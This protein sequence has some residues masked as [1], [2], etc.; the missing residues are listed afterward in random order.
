[1]QSTNAYNTKRVDIA[2]VIVTIAIVVII[3]SQVVYERGLQAGKIPLIAGTVVVVISIINYFLR[4]HQNVKALI[5]ALLP[6]LIV[7]ALFYFD[8]FAVNKHYMIIITIAMVT[9][10]FKKELILIYGIV[11]NI[12]MVVVYQIAPQGLM[13]ADDTILAFFKVLTMLDGILILLY[14]LTKWGN[15]LVNTAS[16]KEEESSK[17]LKKLEHSMKTMEESADTLDSNIGDIDTQMKGISDASKGILDSVQQMALAIQAE[18][19]FKVNETMTS[20]LD[21]VNQ[22]LQTSEGIVKKSDAISHKVEDGWNKM[23][24]VTEHMGTVNTA[25]GTTTDTVTELKIS[26]EEINHLLEG[27][28]T[29]AGQTNLLALNASI[30][31]ARAG[32]HGKGFAV[33]AEQIRNLSNQSRAIVE[34]INVVTVKIFEKSEAASRVSLEGEKASSEGMQLIREV[35]AYFNDIKESYQ[36]NNHELSSSMKEVAVAANNFIEAQ[37]QIT[38]LASISEENSA[39]TEE[40]LSIMEG[41]NEQIAHINSSVAEVHSLSRKLKDLVNEN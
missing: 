18:G 13:A 3:C 24:M 28:K 25:I 15:E 4:I 39:S 21:V 31:S 14:F 8:R 16:T 19:I 1:M 34:D 9:L 2:N 11:M 20:S 41:E 32:E 12:A 36:E 27:I 22:T 38:N 23:N 17:L 37:E 29:I 30:E 26:L 5:F 7:M 35:A 10:Y 6:G 33:V 40:I